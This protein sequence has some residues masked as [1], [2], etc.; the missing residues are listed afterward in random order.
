MKRIELA[1]TFTCRLGAPLSLR[2]ILYRGKYISFFGPPTTVADEWRSV[3]FEKDPF[4]NPDDPAIR[5]LS[6]FRKSFRL[7]LRFVAR[8]VQLYDPT[9][10]YET[11]LSFCKK[12]YLVV[13]LGMNATRCNYQTNYKTFTQVFAA[14]GNTII[15][16]YF[17]RT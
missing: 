4:G 10:P 12:L 2:D 7:L 14:Y 13:V 5:I 17:A 16:G 9:F 15:H 8:F 11:L 3:S 6:A 1:V